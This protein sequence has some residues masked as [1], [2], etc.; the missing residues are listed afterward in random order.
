MFQVRAVCKL[1]IE[2]AEEQRGRGNFS[3]FHVQYKCF[4]WFH[5]FSNCSLSLL[6]LLFTSSEGTY[7]GSKIW[8]QIVTANEDIANCKCFLY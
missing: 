7:G 4:L 5:P 1:L 3:H 8:G 6:L 2:R